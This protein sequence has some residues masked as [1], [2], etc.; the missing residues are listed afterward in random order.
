MPHLLPALSNFVPAVS[1]NQDDDKKSAPA[2]LYCK[3]KIYYFRYAFPANLRKS[4]GRAELRV[5]LKTSYLR[6]ARF[7]ARMLSAE[8]GNMILEGFMLDYKEIRRRMNILLQRLLEQDHADLSERKNISVGKLNITYDQLRTSQIELL[9]HCNSPQLLEQIAPECIVDLLRSGAFTRS[10]LAGENYLQIV[11]AYKEMQITRHRIDIARTKGDFFMEEE[12]MGRDFGKLPCDISCTAQ[13]PPALMEVPTHVHQQQ[14]GGILYSEAMERY[15]GQKL[16][17]GEWREHSVRDHRGRLEEFL[18]IIGDKPIKEITRLDMR[19]FRETLRRL[20]PNRSRVKDFKNKT[21]L[22][23]LE[24]KHDKTLNV[25]T[26]N[27]Y[28][29]SISG[30]LAWYVR[31]GL[32]DANPATHL[33]IKDSRQAIEL[34]QAFSADELTKIFAHP[35]FAR[36]EFKSPSYYWIPLIALFTGMRLEEIAQ[37]HCADIY[38]SQTKGIWVIDINSN[39][40]DELGRPKL[41]KNKNARRIVPIHSDLIQMGLLDYHTEIAKNKHIRLFPELKKSEGAVKFGKQPGKQFK[42]VVTAA[43]GEASGKTFHSLRHTF[44]DFF[45]QRGLQNDY[46]RQ[47]FGHELPMLAAKQYGEKFSPSTLYSE[48]IEKLVYDAPIT[49]ECESVSQQISKLHSAQ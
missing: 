33:Q 15:I 30:M 5:S 6:I 37:L 3:R 1:S 25:K 7:R 38:E 11:K 19:H 9:L 40:L 2:Y 46:F 32:L 27:I 18:I 29:E 16:Q 20:P 21:I 44:A 4:L 47:V 28:V 8:I 24:I 14:T 12:V 10:E 26:I 22:E 17:D 35:K 43:L 48:V 13:E 23:L 36:K 45:K 42:A 34:R 41:L 31:E 49:S 39:G